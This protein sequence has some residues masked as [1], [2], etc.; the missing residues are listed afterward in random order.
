MHT[1][2]TEGVAEKRLSHHFGHALVNHEV[3]VN[4]YIAMDP[5]PHDL[6]VNSRLGVEEKVYVT[7]AQ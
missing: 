3:E 6:S 5:T 2:G 7:E 1:C 4:Q